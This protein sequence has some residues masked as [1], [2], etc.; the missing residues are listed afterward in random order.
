MD[1]T[2]VHQGYVLHHLSSPIREHCVLD[3]VATADVIYRLRLCLWLC[4]VV[5]GERCEPNFDHVS[6]TSR[7]RRERRQ[8]QY[9]SDV[10]YPYLLMIA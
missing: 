3:S 2:N 7:R 10:S 1:L 8:E 6:P 4:S 9:Q 5:R